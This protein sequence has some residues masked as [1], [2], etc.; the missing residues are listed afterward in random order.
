MI[1]IVPMLLPGV[2]FFLLRHRMRQRAAEPATKRAADALTR[3]LLL[4][5]LLGAVV[6]GILFLAVLQGRVMER[7]THALIL[8]SLWIY[9]TTFYVEILK[10]YR[11]AAYLAVCAAGSALA[12][13]LAVVFTP[14]DRYVDL[15]HSHLHAGAYLLGLVMLGFFYLGQSRK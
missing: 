3:F 4:A 5:P 15:L 12:V 9:V 14:L 1:C 8:L 2:L 7:G 11:N 6:F 13:G 10:H